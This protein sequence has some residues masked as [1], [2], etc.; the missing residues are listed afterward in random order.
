MVLPNNS[1]EVGLPLRLPSIILIHRW[2]TG[3]RAFTGKWACERKI[4]SGTGYFLLLI[5]PENLETFRWE[6]IWSSELLPACS[7]QLQWSTFN[8]KSAGKLAGIQPKPK[9]NRAGVDTADRRSRS[10]PGLVGRRNQSTDPDFEIFG[11]FPIQPGS[12]SHRSGCRRT[13]NC[14]PIDLKTTTS[15][16]HRECTRKFHDDIWNPDL[17]FF[18]SVM[19]HWNSINLIRPG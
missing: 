11:W 9:G 19:D 2:R 12:Q 10:R 16:S 5:P 14:G 8:A 13:P 17:H 4:S 18:K 1:V 15:S 3:K 7:F 6:E